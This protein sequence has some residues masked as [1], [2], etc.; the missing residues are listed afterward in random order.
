[1]VEEANDREGKE[2]QV[3]KHCRLLSSDGRMGLLL[4]ISVKTELPLFVIIN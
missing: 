4:M 3:A 1:M 2:R